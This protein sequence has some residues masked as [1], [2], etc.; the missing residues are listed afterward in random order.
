MESRAPRPAIPDW[1]G[2]APVAPPSLQYHGQHLVIGLNRDSQGFALIE[3]FFRYLETDNDGPF[4]F[5]SGEQ[6]G[7]RRKRRFGTFF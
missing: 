7:F 5:G 4:L 2:E 6:F 1:T 3:N